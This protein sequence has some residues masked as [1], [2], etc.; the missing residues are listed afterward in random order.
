MYPEDP[1]LALVHDNLDPTVGV[2]S[3]G[4]SLATATG[5]WRFTPEHSGTHNREF[6][7][8]TPGDTIYCF[9]PAPLS[10]VLLLELPTQATVWLEHSMAVSCATPG[11][12]LTSAHVEYTR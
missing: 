4:T 8:I 10:G 2:F 9:D 12:V 1:H 6:S 7:E 5:A 3:I 11:L